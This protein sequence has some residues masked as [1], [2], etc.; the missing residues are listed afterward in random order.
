VTSSDLDTLPAVLDVP[1]AADVL[2]IGRTLAYQL[3]Q[4]GRWPTPVLHL[5]RKIRIPTVALLRLLGQDMVAN[6]A[7]A[8]AYPQIESG[9]FPARPAAASVE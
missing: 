2:G 8:P 7:A 1:R 9:L 5:G 6:P 3:I 4:T